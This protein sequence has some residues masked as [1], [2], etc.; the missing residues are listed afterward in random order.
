MSWWTSVRDQVIKPVAGTIAA[1]FTAGA[2]LAAVA[3]DA[4]APAGS[5]DFAGGGGGATSAAPAGAVGGYGVKPGEG[6]QKPPAP[7]FSGGQNT[8]LLIAGGLI[9]LLLVLR[10]R[11]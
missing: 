10:L 4:Q 7:I 1:P 8:L 3:A 6:Q 5:M 9:V 11:R 2:S